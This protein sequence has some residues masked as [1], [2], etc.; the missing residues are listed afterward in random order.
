V[1]VTPTDSKRGE[2][3]SRLAV[4]GYLEKSGYFCFT[5]RALRA[6]GNLKKYGNSCFGKSEATPKRLRVV[7]HAE[8]SRSF[9]FAAGK[10]CFEKSGFSSSGILFSVGRS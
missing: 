5:G 2:F 4:V 8:E 9:C 7:G 1:V 6:G 10:V 3:W